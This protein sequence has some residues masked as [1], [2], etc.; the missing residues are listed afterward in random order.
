MNLKY[1]K[2]AAVNKSTDSFD[3]SKIKKRDLSNVSI[4]SIRKERES[5]VTREKDTK[6]KNMLSNLQRSP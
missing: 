6:K 2:P 5:D 4:E 3:D 1:R